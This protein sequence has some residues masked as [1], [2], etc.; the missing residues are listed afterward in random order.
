M[1]KETKAIRDYFKYHWRK[2]QPTTE[3]DWE[4]YFKDMKENP[5][6]EEDI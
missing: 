1:K 4:K 5:E 6:P 2:N 3:K